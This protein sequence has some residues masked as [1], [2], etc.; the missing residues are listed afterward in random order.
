M[1]WEIVLLDKRRIDSGVQLPIVVWSFFKAYI[2]QGLNFSS[3]RKI[4]VDKY[5]WGSVKFWKGASISGIPKN[6]LEVRS[7]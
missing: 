1:K 3:A 2:W 7:P 4:S 5:S 6:L